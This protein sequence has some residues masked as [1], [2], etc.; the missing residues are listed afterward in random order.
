MINII[1]IPTFEKNVKKIVKKDKLLYKDL[2]RLFEMLT[3]NP[4]EGIY[5]G[6]SCYKI[7]VKN[8]SINKGKSGGYRVITYY[9]DKDTLGLLTIYSKSDRENIFES[10]IDE[11]ISELSENMD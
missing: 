5:L 6:N 11:L 7:R 1:V 10:E 8:S 9:W 3:K 4:K 2:Q